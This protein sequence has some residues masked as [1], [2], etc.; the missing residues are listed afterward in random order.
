MIVLDRPTWLRLIT[1]WHGSAMQRVWPRLLAVTLT[2][3]LITELHVR[4]PIELGVLTPLPFTIVGLALGVFLGF[5]NNTSYDRF[6][7][8]RRFWGELVNTARSFAREVLVLVDSGEERRPTTG[9]T[10]MV[11]T[12]IAFVHVFRQHLRAQYDPSEYES[13]LPETERARVASAHHRPLAV[14]DALGSMLQ[15]AWRA[16]RVDPFHV[17]VLENSLTLFTNQLGGCERIRNTPI[18]MS[19]TTLMHRIVGVYVF[20][21]P[22]GLV[23]S[24][25]EFTPLVV[26]FTAYAFLGLDAI[27]DELENPFGTDP[28]D[29]PLTALSRSIEIDLLAMLGETDLPLPLAPRDDI[30]L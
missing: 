6:W 20:G 15:R 3:V 11:R 26:L 4:T 24:I 21:L 16:G 22:F 2:S 10:E 8:G 5:R 7:E 30:L 19:Y 9:Q 12:A 14:L 18:P 1:V 27:G 17:P 13:L 23:T 25:G 28:N 29:L